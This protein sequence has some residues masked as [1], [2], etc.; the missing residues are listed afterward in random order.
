MV[1][2]FRET[3]FLIFI[4]F[5]FRANL[6]RFSW[7]KKMLSTWSRL[8]IF[9]RYLT[10]LIKYEYLLLLL[11]IYMNKRYSTDPQRTQ[12]Q[13]VFNQDEVWENFTIRICFPQILTDGQIVAQIV[14]DSSCVSLGDTHRSRGCNHRRQWLAKASGNLNAYNVRRMQYDYIFNQSHPNCMYLHVSYLCIFKYLQL[15]Q[16]K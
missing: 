1:D 9:T 12:V 6:G 8:R 10:K 2:I 5:V 15:P 4:Y 11:S 7:I 13:W 16:A 14:M 3:V